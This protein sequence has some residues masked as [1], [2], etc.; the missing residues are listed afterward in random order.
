MTEE[1]KIKRFMYDLGNA[2]ARFRE[3]MNISIEENDLALDAA[4]QRFEF[5]FELFWK[6]L[7]ILLLEVGGVQING[8]KQVLK[9]AYAMGWINE[10]KKWLDLLDARNLTS[11]I[12]NEQKANDI[13]Q[14]IQE[15]A[16]LMHTE[17]AGLKSRFAEFLN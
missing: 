1:E 14:L 5:S 3:V 15:N 16:P 9:E 11:H 4:I 10:E 13:Y 2:L 17:Y 8:P 12:Y 6:T 7:K